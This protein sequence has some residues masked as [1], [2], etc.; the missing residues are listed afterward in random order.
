MGCS[1]S[2]DIRHD[3]GLKGPVHD[4]ERAPRPPAPLRVTQ[5]FEATSAYQ[6]NYPAH[7][8]QPETWKGRANRQHTLVLHSVILAM[9]RRD[10]HGWGIHTPQA[11]YSTS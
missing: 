5:P 7:E 6:E 4:V 2:R 11:V 1:P 3:A 9:S 10:A 8:S